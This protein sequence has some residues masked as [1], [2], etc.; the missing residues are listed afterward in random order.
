MQLM[1]ENVILYRQEVSYYLAIT[2]RQIY[3][4]RFEMPDKRMAEK[5]QSELS[6]MLDLL[7]VPPKSYRLITLGLKENCT[8][9]D[10][11]IAFTAVEALFGESGVEFDFS[12]VV[13]DGEV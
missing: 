5:N 7:D 8:K 9:E 3:R 11:Y 4:F 2:L 1:K 6:G 13:R 10:I 12:G